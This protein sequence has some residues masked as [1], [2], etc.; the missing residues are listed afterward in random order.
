[1]GRMARMLR[2]QYPFGKDDDSDHDTEERLRNIRTYKKDKKHSF[3]ISHK[4]RDVHDLS[5]EPDI[6][7]RPF[8]HL[9]MTM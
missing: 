3:I 2:S 5:E 6:G 7:V 4:K 8:C 9:I 1:M